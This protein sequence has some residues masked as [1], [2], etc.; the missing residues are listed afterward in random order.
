MKW[1]LKN[2]AAAAVTGRCTVPGGAASPLATLIPRPSSAPLA[3][4]PS[5]RPK[6]TALSKKPLLKP[7]N[8]GSGAKNSPLPS[9]AV[10]HLGRDKWRKNPFQ[11]TPEPLNFGSKTV[12]D[13]ERL[14][15]V[16]TLIHSLSHSLTHSLTH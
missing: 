9:P 3:G 13:R 2:A 12:L 11:T 8:A 4:I 16:G 7:G 5:A 14:A 15:G 6:S 10:V 1:P